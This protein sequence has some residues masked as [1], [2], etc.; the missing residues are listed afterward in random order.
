[1]GYSSGPETIAHSTGIILLLFSVSIPLVIGNFIIPCVVDGTACIFR[2]PGLPMIPLYGDVD[3]TTMKSIHVDVEC[4]SSPIFTKS[5]ICPNGHFISPLNPINEM[6]FR[7]YICGALDGLRSPLLLLGGLPSLHRLANVG[8]TFPD[9][10]RSFELS[11]VILPFVVTESLELPEVSIFRRISDSMHE[12]GDSHAFRCSF[13]ISTFRL[14]PL[15]EVF[16]GLSISL[17]DVVEHYWVSDALFL[18]EVV[19]QECF[20]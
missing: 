12:S 19:F 11:F 16:C 4:S 10:V 18:L 1:M 14:I 8:T 3:L 6:T 7:R 9:W 15:Y 17:L 20:S 5:V 13:N 2:N